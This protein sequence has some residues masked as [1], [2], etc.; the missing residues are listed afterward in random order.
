MTDATRA[1]VERTRSYLLA[2]QLPEDTKDGLQTLL[3][4]AAMATNST[5][6]RIGAMA[7]AILAL[8]LHEVRQ[9]V[10]TPDAIQ[11][12]VADAISAH[13]ATCPIAGQGKQGALV[14]LAM[15]PWPWLFA[16]VAVF[17]PHAPRIVE[18]LAGLAAR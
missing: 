12:A 1:K 17:S 16:A 4:A 18:T 3:D 10:R 13:L 8:S 5:Q 14:A 7:D 11:D 6:D 2:S 9:A 15:K